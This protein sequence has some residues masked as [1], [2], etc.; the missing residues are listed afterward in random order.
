MKPIGTIENGRVLRF[1]LHMR[2]Q[3]ILLMVSLIILAITGFALKY[4]DSF[5]GKILMAIE[6]GMELRGFI[7]RFFAVILLADI[8]YHVW[9]V[10]FT[11]EGHREFMLLKP[12]WRDVREFFATVRYNLTGKGE[13]PLY[14]KY[15]YREKFQYWGVVVGVS[16]MVVTGL[17]LWFET[18]SMA[19]MPKWV[20][21]VT[22]VIH[23]GEGLLLFV[24][25][26]LWHGYNVHFS[27]K[28]FFNSSF[29]TGWEDLEYVKK[30]RPL[31][32]QRY[33]G[34]AP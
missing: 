33:T 31:E 24:I 10:V 7:H 19:I 28:K 3:H 34:E 11:E 6:G 25:L 22:A 18:I 1:S 8:I 5:L 14:D 21:D 30:E 9:Y 13:K 12:S 32:Y 23:G 26:F 17:V 29:I 2:I 16:L 27:D 20:F 4:H 15:S